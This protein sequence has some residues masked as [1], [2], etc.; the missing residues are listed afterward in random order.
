MYAILICVFL[1]IVIYT[2]NGGK[3]N[4]TEYLGIPLLL[5]ILSNE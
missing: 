5:H 3:K 2:S 4:Q 1:S